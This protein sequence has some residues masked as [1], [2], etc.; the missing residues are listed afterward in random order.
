MSNKFVKI[1]NKVLLD[2]AKEYGKVINKSQDEVIET[3]LAFYFHHQMYV[4]N[5]I[6]PAHEAIKNIAIDPKIELVEKL[7]KIDSLYY[8]KT[9]VYFPE[10]HNHAIQ[11]KNLI[12]KANQAE[13]TINENN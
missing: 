9:G 8:E 10:L 3:A 12:L 6:K 2:N 5:E 4:I 1:N 7:V 11:Q 13:K